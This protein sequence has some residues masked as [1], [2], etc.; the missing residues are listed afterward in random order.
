[1]QYRTFLRAEKLKRMFDQLAYGSLVLD[2]AIAAV[3]LVSINVYSPELGKIQYLLNVA[4]SAEVVLAVFLFILIAL[5][6]HYERLVQK[7]Q[8]FRTTL[9]R[10]KHGR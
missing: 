8:K 5:H 3:T 10:K 6:S 9:G 4:L 2:F 1:M 7:L